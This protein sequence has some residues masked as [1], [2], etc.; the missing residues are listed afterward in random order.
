MTHIY[1]IVRQARCNAEHTRVLPGFL[2]WVG[3]EHYSLIFKVTYSTKCVTLGTSFSIEQFVYSLFHPCFCV[4]QGVYALGC[5]N[6]SM[7]CRNNFSCVL[8]TSTKILIMSKTEVNIGVKLAME[9]NGE[10]LFRSEGIVIIP[11]FI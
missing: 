10:Y 8:L 1:A 9:Q 11:R 3:R 5:L 6:R 7:I 2:K 4:S